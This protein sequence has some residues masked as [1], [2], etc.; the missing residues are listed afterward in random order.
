MTGCDPFD[1]AGLV[2]GARALQQRGARNVL[3]SRGGEGAILLDEN[4]RLHQAPAPAGTL[5]NSV[6][7]GDSTVAGFVAGYTQAREDGR[8]ED[9]AYV[10][11][12]ALAQACGSATAFSPGLA[13]RQTI[14]DLLARI[15]G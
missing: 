3:V 8:D 4:G 13:T 1:V 5:V 15:E 9:A 7:A 11:A 6:G 14:D 2:E 10:H 12:F